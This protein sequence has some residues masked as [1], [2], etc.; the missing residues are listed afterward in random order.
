MSAVDMDRELPEATLLGGPLH[1]WGRRLGL[2]RGNGNSLPLG[3]AI[4]LTLWLVGVLLAMV[5][6]TNPWTMGM[7]GAHVRLLLVIPLMFA[8]ESLLNPRVDECVRAL[9]RS[10]IMPDEEIPLLRAHMVRI[11]RWNNTAWIDAMCLLAAIGLAFATPLLEVPGVD[12]FAHIAPGSELPWAGWWYV[13]VCLT[14]FRFLLLR[15]LCRWMLWIYWLWRISRLR[16]QLVASHPD[17]MAG[18]GHLELVHIQV[19]PLVMAFSATAASSFAVEIAAGRMPLEAVYPSLLGIILIDAILFI[20]PLLLFSAKLWACRIHTLGNY[21]VMGARYAAEFER[22]W[23]TERQPPDDLLG[24][25]DIQSMADLTGAR[26]VVSDMR[27]IPIST[28]SMMHL[29][30]AAL[31]PFTPLLLFKYPLLDLIAQILTG[32]VGF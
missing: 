1:R 4:G 5:D 11:L 9:L 14:T 13:A 19:M 26:Q 31:L 12:V 28:R 10:R 18:L 23:H 21:T 15:W 22:K 29:L 24:N 20:G 2:V 7:I 32:L 25:A 8:C 6:G 30:L 27:S 16:L 17:G 3:I